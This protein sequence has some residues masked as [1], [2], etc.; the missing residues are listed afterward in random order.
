MEKD[1]DTKGCKQWIPSA[2]S[3][4]AAFYKFPQGYASSVS[5]ASQHHSVFGA[6]QEPSNDPAQY[7]SSDKDGIF[8]EGIQVQGSNVPAY[9]SPSSKKMTLK[10]DHTIFGWVKRIQPLHGRITL[11]EVKR[12][13][14]GDDSTTITSFKLEMDYQNSRLVFSNAEHQDFLPYSF[15][16]LALKTWY[17]FAVSYESDTQRFQLY[18]NG[19]PQG[20]VQAT[21]D[22]TWSNSH[23]FK[24]KCLENTSGEDINVSVDVCGFIP[25]TKLT[26]DTAKKLFTCQS[27]VATTKN[28]GKP[29][30]Q[31]GPD[32]PRSASSDCV[33]P[34][35]AMLR[36]VCHVLCNTKYT[37]EHFNYLWVN[38]KKKQTSCYISENML[39]MICQKNSEGG[40]TCGKPKDCK[41]ADW[42][43]ADLWSTCSTTCA[44]GL[45][46]TRYR[47]RPITQRPK[48]GG[49]RCNEY[50]TIQEVRCNLPEPSGGGD[51]GDVDHKETAKANI[52]HTKKEN[53]EEK[54]LRFTPR[55]RS[56]S[57]CA[58]MT[59]NRI[60]SLKDQGNCQHNGGGGGGGGEKEEEND[61]SVENSGPVSSFPSSSPRIGKGILRTDP[62]NTF[63]DKAGTGTINEPTPTKNWMPLPNTTP[64]GG[65]KQL[66]KN[67]PVKTTPISIEGTK[68]ISP[69][70]CAKAL[71]QARQAAAN[72]AEIKLA[73]VKEGQQTSGKCY[74]I[75]YRSDAP[76]QLLNA[77]ENIT[78][79]L[80]L[81]GAFEA[82]SNNHALIDGPCATGQ[83]CQLTD[84]TTSREC[85]P[86]K[87]PNTKLEVRSVIHGARGN[88]CP[89]SAYQTTREVPCHNLKKCSNQHNEPC[90]YG[91]YS[92]NQPSGDTSPCAELVNT[93]QSIE[94]E[95][96]IAPTGVA[97]TS[98]YDI[99]NVLSEWTNLFENR[100]RYMGITRYAPLGLTKT[101][102][103]SLKMLGFSSTSS[104]HVTADPENIT[105]WVTAR[106]DEKGE[107]PVVHVETSWVGITLGKK[108]PFS[109][110][111]SL[112]HF[113]QSRVRTVGI[114]DKRTAGVL[115]IQ[116]VSLHE[117]SDADIRHWCSSALF[118][119]KTQ[120]KG[121]VRVQWIPSKIHHASD[122]DLA[123]SSS[124][125]SSSSSAITPLQAECKHAS[126]EFTEEVY[127]DDNDDD[128]N[129]ENNLSLKQRTLPHTA[130]AVRT[131]TTRSLP[132][133]TTGKQVSL[134]FQW[135]TS[136]VKTNTDQKY[137]I[138]CAGGT[139][140]SDDFPSSTL[141]L[142]GVNKVKMPHGQWGMYTGSK[143]SQGKP[144]ASWSSKQ[145]PGLVDWLD[146]SQWTL[147]T[148]THVPSNTSKKPWT[149][150][151]AH[152]MVTTNSNNSP[153][154]QKSLE[155]HVDPSDHT[156]RIFAGDKLS[157]DS[158]L[159][160]QSVT[161]PASNRFWNPSY[162]SFVALQRRDKTTF[163]LFINDELIVNDSNKAYNISWSKADFVQWEWLVLGDDSSK[164]T[165]GMGPVSLWT[166]IL[167][168][169]VLTE[170]VYRRGALSPQAPGASAIWWNFST[171]THSCTV[172]D[173]ESDVD[174]LCVGCAGGKVCPSSF[175]SSTNITAKTKDAGR[176]TLSNDIT[177]IRF[178][179]GTNG[180]VY[181]H[182]K[183]GNNI[184][185]T[186][187]K[188][189]ATKNW[190]ISF[191]W[192]PRLFPSTSSSVPGLCAFYISDQKGR[193]IEWTVNASSRTICVAR[194]SDGKPAV[195]PLTVP[196]EW[197]SLLFS[198]GTPSFITL[199]K[200]QSVHQ[201]EVYVNGQ[202]LQS[203]K[204]S[205][206]PTFAGDAAE[207]QTNGGSD[208]STT[209]ARIGMGG[210]L[211]L[212]L[213]GTNAT[214]AMSQ[215]VGRFI[216][217]SRSVTP[218]DIHRLYHASVPPVQWEGGMFHCTRWRLPSSNAS[219]NMTSPHDIPV[220]SANPSAY[221]HMFAL[222]SPGAQLQFT[223]RGT[224]LPQ[225]GSPASY[226]R[227]PR[228]QS[229]MNSCPTHQKLSG[230]NGND[231]NA[232][233]TFSFSSSS[234]PDWVPSS[235]TCDPNTSGMPSGV[236]HRDDFS[237]SARIQAINVETDAKQDIRPSCLIQKTIWDPQYDS[238]IQNGQ[239]PDIRQVDNL[240][241]E[242]SLSISSLSSTGVPRPVA[243][244]SL[245]LP[246]GS[247]HG[248]GISLSTRLRA[249]KTPGGGGGED[250]TTP[251]MIPSSLHDLR[252]MTCNFSHVTAKTHFT[253]HN[254]Q[255]GDSIYLALKQKGG[256]NQTT[257]GLTG[258]DTTTS[259][260][261][262]SHGLFGNLAI[263]CEKGQGLVASQVPSSFQKW[264]TS[265][266][267]AA[268]SSKGAIGL[269]V[270]PYRW[271][272]STNGTQNIDA[273]DNVRKSDTIRK[274]GDG[275]DNNG[276]WISLFALRGLDKNGNVVAV[277]EY[278]V[279]SVQKKL[280]VFH[281]KTDQGTQ[282]RIA[283]FPFQPDI[284]MPSQRW[285]LLTVV[286]NS[287]NT[288]TIYVGHKKLHTV[289]GSCMN[290]SQ[291]S[292]QIQSWEMTLLDFRS[293]QGSSTN[294]SI[295][296]DGFF[297]LMSSSDITQS[298][299]K[300]LATQKQKYP[301]LY[302]FPVS[303]GTLQTASVDRSTQ[304]EPEF[305]TN[306][307]STG[308]YVFQPDTR[309]RL[310][311]GPSSDAYLI[312]SNVPW[313]N[314]V[315]SS[316]GRNARVDNATTKKTWSLSCW[317]HF[318]GKW[319]TADN[320]TY[321]IATLMPKT[322]DWSAPD[323]TFVGLAIDPS[324][325]Q[326]VLASTLSSLSSSNL[327]GVDATQKCP[328]GEWVHLCMTRSNGGKVKLYVNA[329]CV[330]YISPENENGQTWL[331]TNSVWAGNHSSD[332]VQTVL[333]VNRATTSQK[334]SVEHLNIWQ[335]CLEQ[336]DVQDVYKTHVQEYASAVSPIIRGRI[337]RDLAARLNTQCEAAIVGY[338][339]QYV[340]SNSKEGYYLNTD[341]G[342]W[343][344]K[345]DLT[346][347][348]KCKQG[349]KAYKNWTQQRKA[350]TSSGSTPTQCDGNNSGK[351]NNLSNR[352]QMTTKNGTLFDINK[353][354]YV[355]P[356]VCPFDQSYC[357][358]TSCSASCGTGHQLVL[359]QQRTSS[360]YCRLSEQ[361]LSQPCNQKPCPLPCPY[362][363]NGTMCFHPRGGTCNSNTGKCHCKTG[364]T[365]PACDSI[366]PRGANGRI[367][368]GNGT[369]MANGHCNCKSGYT[370]AACDV[371]KGVFLSRLDAVYKYFATGEGVRVW[372][373]KNGH[374]GEKSCGN[375][376]R[377]CNI[378]WPAWKSYT[379]P[380]RSV[381][382]TRVVAQGKGENGTN[383]G[384]CPVGDYHMSVTEH[385]DA[386]PASAALMYLPGRECAGDLIYNQAS[387]Q[388]K[389]TFGHSFTGEGE[390]GSGSNGTDS[391]YTRHV[392]IDTSHCV[393]NACKNIPIG[394]S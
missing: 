54:N 137:Q 332:I 371:K 28:I 36:A 178:M 24:I 60:L 22:E 260:I 49:Q 380:R 233:A 379:L 171:H 148:W 327:S 187:F 91:P 6:I 348:E 227:D 266:S 204:M 286:R 238:I 318:S 88:G 335:D 108:A 127:E 391:C 125:S 218:S 210:A 256:D 370:G 360:K 170:I 378:C 63:T 305:E 291:Y 8:Q 15:L 117:L 40:W 368:S 264:W 4:V 224:I 126:D 93:K 81:N 120:K 48:N 350:Q 393:A 377:N 26:S 287:M 226:L 344:Y 346:T 308:Q 244:F 336:S 373:S 122:N 133:P 271:N 285:T 162:S 84:W 316:D 100:N 106:K 33:P 321:L 79:H 212:S 149:L 251:R 69:A 356:S 135:G 294:P 387:P 113:I 225:R 176:E 196:S 82:T 147:T 64:K 10:G 31:D 17:L 324:S 361:V 298:H 353:G 80:L 243:Y 46:G 283:V 228:Q 306:V 191:W 258:V 121:N 341:V 102:T 164:Q 45:T 217:W 249:D 211:P 275:S 169:F 198:T 273:R 139:S 77:P 132:S 25:N 385:Y 216:V 280:G 259:S 119:K 101:T 309:P 118:Y 167:P 68:T 92:T 270:C 86:C 284:H 365:G 55:I 151:A 124:L 73:Y 314:I 138:R 96:T 381:E 71:H 386:P 152:Y 2:F 67:F 241:F 394:N 245:K 307:N 330:G 325:K 358:W 367:C 34:S 213:S 375:D 301:P 175:S 235:D 103:N 110:R 66:R 14:T 282:K 99:P 208:N 289:Q 172:S 347:V 20:H 194:G 112:K 240:E 188:N 186:V 94:K 389:W 192:V 230:D 174:G 39:K 274:S 261:Y 295:S 267:D 87:P 190:T 277:E 205:Q 5:N 30:F 11:L 19:Q 315:F 248:S 18:I 334:A 70:T 237:L 339:C 221:Y 337:P 209:K 156:I 189:I 85:P 239:L 383:T 123:V 357:N 16:T 182:D 165:I 183:N 195:S 262:D 160:L 219:G 331:P 44:S 355:C 300:T 184:V 206:W 201:L 311:M 268:S 312:E 366:C 144:V 9:T 376:K 313:Q 76:H 43:K 253:V 214:T 252:G 323:P 141:F 382:R 231:L 364:F 232:T 255:G 292:S 37:K 145:V 111:L 200:N 303:G 62:R 234:P 279:N 136:A 57:P 254:Y 52:R 222:Q 153:T 250:T 32:T 35:W 53:H 372:E 320:G 345:K 220:C 180:L 107:T 12:Q 310:T 75:Q 47:R 128:H 59:A 288:R 74:L 392:I 317:V 278:S 38:K 21:K 369:C 27:N 83:N 129:E 207:W 115:R 181:K 98:D 72:P 374:T 42:D 299:V 203:T 158:S 329:S 343:E 276:V 95:R 202:L 97:F 146:R 23:P 179:T 163:Q 155:F 140:C 58:S 390:S 362:A 384:K 351:N 328:S 61:I 333:V 3:H 114:F 242:K 166:S 388:M 257:T 13:D 363:F 304:A 338:Q 197:D 157:T 340:S 105:R 359:R 168:S 199:R 65:L 229:G 185:G 142:K 247:Q 159:P 281:Y 29:D 297:W 290:P 51:G 89:C 319:N 263:K 269:W 143:A 193:T 131:R 161:L 7:F 1:D 154:S 326:F 150:F 352:L 90:Y 272:H 41:Y 302:K 354:R 104:S 50:E 116:P 236:I 322:R 215:S 130:T 177:A 293:F 173:N 78:D 342:A 56:S 265:A 296:L 134:T 223:L 349:E 109:V 246:Q